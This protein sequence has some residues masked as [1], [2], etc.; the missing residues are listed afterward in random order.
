METTT[1]EKN[2]EKPN[3]TTQVKLIYDN[4]QNVQELSGVFTLKDC[5]DLNLAIEQLSLFFSDTND[6][7]VATQTTCNAMNLLM[8]AC[9]VAQKT[10]KI[11]FKGAHI[12]LD[13]LEGLN[14]E[15]DKHKDPALK[16]QELKAKIVPQRTKKNKK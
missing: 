12:I 2:I 7:K 6:D 15:I 9:A 14:V 1:S 13:I 8:N 4:L 10:G 11:T 5:K 16:M 3:Y